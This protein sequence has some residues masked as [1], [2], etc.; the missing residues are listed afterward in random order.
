M[1]PKYKCLLLVRISTTKQVQESD[2][3]EHQIRRGL[4]FAEKRYGYTR[5]QVFILT[6]AWSG[7]REDRPCLDQ[8]LDMVEKHGLLHLFVYDIDRLTRAG[9]AHYELL[10][11]KF[12]AAG[13][14]IADVKGIIQP[15]SNTLEGTG[16]TFGDDFAYD[17]SVFA[18]SEKAEVLEA[19]MAKDEARKI[20]GRTVPVLI[21]NAQL[22]RTNRVAP[23]GFRNTKI[24]DDSGKP[25]PSKVPDEGEAFFV[26]RIF[27]GVA[28]GRDVRN[29]CD[30]LNGLGFQTRLVRRWTADHS[31]VIGKRGGKPLTPRMVRELVERTVY[32]GFICEKWTHGFPVQAN[33]E[34]LVAL[35]LWNHA[36]RG[37]WRLIKDG[38]SPTGWSRIDVRLERQRRS[39]LRARADFPF[40]TLITCPSCGKPM[41]AGYSR[42]RN[43]ERYGYYQC[44]RGHKQV[45]QAKDALHSTIQRYLDTMQFTEQV[46]AKFDQ[47]L[48]EAWIKKV[49]GLNKHLAVANTEVAQLRE[50]ADSLFE[51]IKIA[52]NPLIIRR[53]EQE[54]EDLFQRI[55]LLE[56]KRDEKE[57]TEADMNRAISWAKY[58]VEHL[59]ELITE[60]DDESLRASFWSLV[61]ERH[62][63][64][65]EL[66]N[67]TA[68]LSVL[69]RL[70]AECEK[71]KGDL[72]GNDVFRLN[73]IWD[74]LC[75]WETE[76]SAAMRCNPGKFDAW[77]FS[78]EDDLPTAA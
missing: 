65:A 56:A 35:D 71:A 5:D 31:K 15:D 43:G 26:R 76:L 74:E 40:K 20:L 23:Y 52:Q 51:K 7:R 53:L 36:N 34:G 54:Y 22:G 12:K 8:A 19:Q 59:D 61:F 21:Q 60:T 29:L 62:P 66:Q 25:Q 2:S 72:V 16:G 42:S 58:L 18:A 49:G 47:Y 55:K 50:E 75:R 28:A 9:A 27:E 17:W 1:T 4:A 39:Y 30:D 46:G 63:T 64:L 24:I 32:A 67:R 73:Q 3:P 78:N 69:V 6:E 48:R 57:F 77:P 70:K 11:R 45:S 38:D 68:P 13:C 37:K 33:H 14:E 44:A 10:K 41:K